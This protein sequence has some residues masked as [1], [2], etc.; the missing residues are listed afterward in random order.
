MEGGDGK[1][2]KKTD[3]KKNYQE[4][5]VMVEMVVKVE[6]AVT[7]VLC[8]C[9]FTSAA[10]IKSRITVYN[11]VVQADMLRRRCGR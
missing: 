2:G 6:M 5:A 1:D 8:T 9:S 10:D 3:K 7:E 11:T 4:M